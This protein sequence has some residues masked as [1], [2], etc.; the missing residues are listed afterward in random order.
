MKIYFPLPPLHFLN[1]FKLTE[2]VLD[3]W[4]HIFVLL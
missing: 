3:V 1:L 2:A 4:Y